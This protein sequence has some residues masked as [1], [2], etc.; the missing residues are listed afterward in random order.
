ML[1]KTALEW[2]GGGAYISGRRGPAECERPTGFIGRI[3]DYMK[4]YPEAG[5]AVGFTFL[6]V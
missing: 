6:L 4:I 3:R 1:L 5:G 2:V